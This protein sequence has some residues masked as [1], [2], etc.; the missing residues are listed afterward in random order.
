LV[1]FTQSQGETEAIRARLDA[2]AGGDH[3]EVHFPASG[4]YRGD[5][6]EESIDVKIQETAPETTT[7]R[8]A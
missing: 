8:T 4:H 6:M 7:T 1:C 5:W 2:V 3:L